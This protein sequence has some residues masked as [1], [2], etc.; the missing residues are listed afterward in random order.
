MNTKKKLTAEQA[1][2]C[3]L[4]YARIEKEEPRCLFSHYKDSLY[5]FV[6]RTVCLQYEF[7]VDAVDGTVWGI[8]TEPLLYPE[9]LLF[10]AHDE[11]A[12]PAVA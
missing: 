8:N 4:I 3:A 6:V 7:Y 9:T 12:R 2:G 5:Q 1:L 10:W 11:Q